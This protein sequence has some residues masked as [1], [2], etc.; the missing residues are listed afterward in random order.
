MIK[1]LVIFLINDGYIAITWAYNFITKLATCIFVKIHTVI[2][3]STHKISIQTYSVHY[4][5]SK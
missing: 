4:V 5:H 1:L 2:G 3:C